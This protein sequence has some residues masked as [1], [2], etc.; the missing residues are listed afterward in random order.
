MWLVVQ[1][2]AKGPELGAI[3]HKDSWEEAVNLA[4]NMVQEQCDTP[5]KEIR[6]EI[7][8]DTDFHDPGG[9]WAIA[10]GQPEFK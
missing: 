9:D 4:V 6:E 8:S 10:I 5:E 7:E 3:Y 1:I 2:F